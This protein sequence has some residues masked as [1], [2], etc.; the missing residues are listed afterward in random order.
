[1]ERGR[2]KFPFFWG[3]LLLKVLRLRGEK[4]LAKR[5]I[6][7]QEERPLSEPL[8]LNWTGWVLQQFTD[9]VVSE[10]VFAEVLRK[11]RG[12]LQKIHFIA[13]GKGAEILLKVCRNLWKFF[14]NDP[15]LND[16][17]SELLSFYSPEK[18]RLLAYLFL[19]M[20]VLGVVLP[21]FLWSRNS[22]FCLAWLD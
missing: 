6:S 3:N 18:W 21:T 20:V 5:P 2:H 11:V 19:F 12:D 13:S 9:G 1:M 4:L 15:F 22:R 17:I 16:T 7:W 8:F 14:C 10:G